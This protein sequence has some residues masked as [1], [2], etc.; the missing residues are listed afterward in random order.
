M[1]R[2]N[3]NL[4]PSSTPQISHFGV[5][6]SWTEFLQGMTPP[7][8]RVTQPSNVPPFSSLPTNLFF[9]SSVRTSTPQEHPLEKLNQ[10]ILELQSNRRPETRKAELLRAIDALESEFP[11]ITEAVKLAY[12]NINRSPLGDPDWSSNHITDNL[13]FL[14]VSIKNVLQE[15][16]N[17]REDQNEIY[18][19]VAQAAGCTLIR[20]VERL[21][22]GQHAVVD[23][24]PRLAKALTKPLKLVVTSVAKGPNAL[25]TLDRK[26]ASARPHELVGHI[27]AVDRILPGFSGQ[28]LDAYYHKCTDHPELDSGRW[29][30]FHITDD[31]GKLREAVNEQL[32]VRLE[33]LGT[34]KNVFAG[35]IYEIA[36]AKDSSVGGPNWGERNALADWGRFF[37]AYE[38]VLETLGTVPETY[39][40]LPERVADTPIGI[41]NGG[42][43][44]WINSDMQLLMNTPLRGLLITHPDHQVQTFMQQYDFDKRSTQPVALANTQP[45]R[46]LFT[47]ERGISASVLRYEDAHEGFMQLLPNAVL[48]AREAQ[49]HGRSEGQ[50]HP[51]AFQTTTTRKYTET[52]AYRR[53]VGLFGASADLNAEMEATANEPKFYVELELN[54][55]Y[56][57]FREALEHS[58]VDGHVQGNA[59]NYQGCSLP[60]RSVKT[61]FTA[62]FPTHLPIH[63]K[64][65]E[66]L[67]NATKN[68]LKLHIPAEVVLKQNDQYAKYDLKAFVE[69]RG[70]SLNGGHYVT[71]VN[72]GT[73]DAP[74]W[75]LYNDSAA[76]HVTTEEALRHV[77]NAYMPYFEKRDV[78][79]DEVEFQ[80]VNGV[81]DEAFRTWQGRQARERHAKQTPL[82]SMYALGSTS[83]N[84]HYR[85]SSDSTSLPWHQKVWKGLF[86]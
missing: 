30:E 48:N 52:D 8:D 66:F 86:G 12:W 57:Q 35:K 68:N 61:E 18:R 28:V 7:L 63:I 50:L 82:Q 32:Q 71:Y 21:T 22:F 69:H 9:N 19:A 43:N 42:A 5:G 17:V 20:D 45:I 41:L 11:G 29:S 65:F 1:F 53:N 77:E 55:D 75:I 4:D 34:K 81:N 80:R 2:S 13:D 85:A 56:L 31:I 46:E 14:K 74:D 72:E 6:S 33:G 84:P 70:A 62:G 27:K 40:H 64:R 25:E 47:S 54:R 59:G 79:V 26:M 58:L 39:S 23:D 38:A 15:R 37:E 10:L 60:L 24:L 44:C 76:T 67:R 73:Y 3:S 16:I 51:L 78:V 49:V 83:G 36:H